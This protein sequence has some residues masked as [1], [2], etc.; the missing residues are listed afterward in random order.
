VPVIAPLSVSAD[1]TERYNVNADQAAGAVAAA[2]GAEKLILVTDVPGIMRPQPDGSKAVVPYTNP[3]EIAGMI[4]A[5]VITG[6]MIPKVQAALDALAQGVEKVVIC[7]GTAEE[8]LAVCAG[9]EAGTTV[10][11]QG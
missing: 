10:A 5:K 11:M 1:G 4:A 3:Q 9:K 7:R 8:L 6:G 2:L